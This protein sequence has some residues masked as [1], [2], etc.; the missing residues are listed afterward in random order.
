M[1]RMRL[2]QYETYFLA[3]TL[4]TFT[5]KAAH[6]HDYLESVLES[7]STCHPPCRFLAKDASN[8]WQVM[9]DAYARLRIEQAFQECMT[10]ERIVAV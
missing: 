3:C 1:I 4:Q 8:G 10:E 9:G 5:R 6:M 2:H 7:F